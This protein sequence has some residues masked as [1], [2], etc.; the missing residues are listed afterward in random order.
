MQGR[1]SK[2][3]VDDYKD[4][5]SSRRYYVDNQDAVS[6]LLQW[7]TWKREGWRCL[8]PAVYLQQ[9]YTARMPEL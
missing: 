4:H 6:G 3:L 1:R 2:P 7:H 9:H 8:W 5:L